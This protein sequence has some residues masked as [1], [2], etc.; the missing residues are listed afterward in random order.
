[1]SLEVM[2]ILSEKLV[3]L[4]TLQRHM[5]DM[6]KENVNTTQKLKQNVCLGSSVQSLTSLSPSV[7]VQSS[8]SGIVCVRNKDK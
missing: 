7:L 1:M 5:E 3:E 8:H 2:K 4:A 6:M